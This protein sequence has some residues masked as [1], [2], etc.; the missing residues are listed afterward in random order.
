MI[1]IFRVENSISLQK[2]FKLQCYKHL[3]LTKEC[4]KNI[5]K[6]HLLLVCCKIFKRVKYVG[7]LSL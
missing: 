4:H 6:T 7:Y 3:N 2:L 1:L 5:G